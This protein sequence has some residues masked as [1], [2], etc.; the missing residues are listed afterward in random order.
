MG[1][2]R[3]LTADAESRACAVEIRPEK[4]LALAVIKQAWNEATQDPTGLGGGSQDDRSHLR[5]A[6]IKWICQD[7]DFSYWCQLADMNHTEVR[8]RLRRTLRHVKPEE[9][10]P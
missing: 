7:E 6:A 2:R 10:A 9:E 5:E 4:N 8:E 1:Y 3:G